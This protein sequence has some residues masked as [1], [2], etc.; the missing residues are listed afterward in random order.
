MKTITRSSEADWKG[1]LKDGH[2][3]ISTQSGV[4]TNANYSFTTRFEGGQ[5]HHANPEELIAAAAAS[6]FSMALSKTLGDA[7]FVPKEIRTRA[8]VGM[9]MGEEGPKIRTLTLEVE[10]RVPSIDEAQFKE[11]AEKTSRACPVMSLFRPAFEEVSVTA[12]LIPA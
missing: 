9:T 4:L 11:A 6:C 5:R 7:N 1:S 2:G 10:G 3:L 8:M 12:S